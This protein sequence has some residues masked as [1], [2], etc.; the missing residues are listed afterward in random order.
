MIKTF[1][2]AVFMT[3]LLATGAQA[4][5]AKSIPNL[6]GIWESTSQMHY[7]EQGHIKPEGKAGTLE[8]L[9]QDGRVIHGAI[10]WN[11]KTSGK[12]TFSGVIDKDGVTFYL[13][14]HTEGIR[15]GKLEGPDAFT[16]YILIPGGATPRA[17][18]AE[19]KRVK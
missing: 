2:A 8:V 13:A 16:L 15:I 3:C 4:Q 19:Y 1:V 12:E 17:G 18:L 7:K 14:G 11:H 6:K 10:E 5:D 9:S